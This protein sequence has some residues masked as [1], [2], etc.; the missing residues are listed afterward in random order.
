MFKNKILKK[1]I[2][3]RKAYIKKNRKK[4]NIFKGAHLKSQTPIQWIIFLN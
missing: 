2:F 1:N 4:L 3:F